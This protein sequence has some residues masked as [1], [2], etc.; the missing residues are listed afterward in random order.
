MNSDVILWLDLAGTAVFAATGAIKGVRHRLDL[1]GIIVLACC[2]GVGGGIIRD[3]ILGAVPAAAL[4]NGWYLLVCI[5]IAFIIFFTA[6][7]W[8]KIRNIIQHFDAI[9]LGVFTALGAAKGLTY[10]VS[11][12]GIVLCGTFTAI[13]GGMIRD[14][15]VREVPVVLRS[16]F[17]ATAAV[18][19]GFLFYALN[20]M[21][22]Q[23]GFNFFT[24]ALVVTTLRLLAMHYH[25]RL[26][27]VQKKNGTRNNT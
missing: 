7:Y 14:I 15:L 6:R 5:A 2:V 9:G 19:G 27:K 8:M 26:P 18:I 12:I 3:M 11:I 16:D 21:D 4:K 13:G 17:Y 22:L 10:D 24:T 1:F 23:W 20:A 25:L